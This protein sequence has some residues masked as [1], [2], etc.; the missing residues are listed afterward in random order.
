M[1]SPFSELQRIL[2]AVYL[3]WH[4][5]WAHYALPPPQEAVFALQL[6][7]FGFLFQWICKAT[8]FWKYFIHLFVGRVDVGYPD[9][10]L[11][12]QLDQKL[13]KMKKKKIFAWSKGN[14]G[15][16]SELMQVM[17]FCN[18]IAYLLLSD[19][20]FFNLRIKID[21]AIENSFSYIFTS[22]SGI[23]IDM[24]IQQTSSQDIFCAWIWRNS[25]M[26]VW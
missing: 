6:I 7:M 8:F 12:D 23:N 26:W 19:L 22:C 4:I 24:L 20:I 10:V 18:C 16:R 5:L 21:F 15:G 3:L 11:W 17:I 9:I 14:K 13:K 1:K 25:H 2:P